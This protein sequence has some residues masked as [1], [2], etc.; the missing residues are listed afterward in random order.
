MTVAPQPHSNP[1]TPE[2][3]SDQGQRHGLRLVPRSSTPNPS[4]ATPDNRPVDPAEETPTTDNTNP[5][6][7]QSPIVAQAPLDVRLLT[8]IGDI[9]RARPRWSQRPPSFAEI[10]DYSTSGDWTAEDKSG[11]RVIHGL[12]VVIAFTVLYPI[13]WA[14]QAALHKPI[15]FLLI[16]TVI[17]ALTK[18]F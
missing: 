14:V 12:C 8:H 5:A 17:F 15:G 10:W 18:V 16:V 2:K 9:L 11:K 3:P 4:W 7:D 13:E 1:P 6:E